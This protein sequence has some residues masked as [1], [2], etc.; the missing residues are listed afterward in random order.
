MRRTV[1]SGSISTSSR[2]VWVSAVGIAIRMTARRRWFLQCY[3]CFVL[4]IY[5]LSLFWADSCGKIKLQGVSAYEYRKGYDAKSLRG[6][7]ER[8][9]VSSPGLGGDTAI[10]V[11]D[12]RNTLCGILTITHQT[13]KNGI[14]SEV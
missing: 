2:P 5:I 4:R 3:L 12:S 14:P 7:S 1:K 13:E 10:P 9:A 6:L 8:K 11:A